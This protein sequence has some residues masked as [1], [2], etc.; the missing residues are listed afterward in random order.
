[1]GDFIVDAED[2]DSIRALLGVETV[3]VED[4]IIDLPAYGPTVEARIKSAVT[5]WETLLDDDEA[6]I[7]LKNAAYYGTAATLAE[8]YV[9]GGTVSLV[10]EEQPRRNW[11]EWARIFWQRYEEFCSRAR[12]ERDPNTEDDSMPMVKFSGPTRSRGVRS[13]WTSYPP[14]W[15]ERS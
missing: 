2:Y 10:H 6:L 14:V 9:K 12:A 1:M 11:S 13:D 3:D 7:F 8:S 5:D 15:P 4:T